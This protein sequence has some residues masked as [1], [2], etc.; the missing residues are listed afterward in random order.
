M[1]YA[2]LFYISRYVSIVN[3]LASELMPQLHM[4]YDNE[5]IFRKKLTIL[6]M[7]AMFASAC[8]RIEC[9]WS[10]GALEMFSLL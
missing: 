7:F 3:G 6:L 5:T 4:T 8:A 10:W 2:I 1:F 9:F